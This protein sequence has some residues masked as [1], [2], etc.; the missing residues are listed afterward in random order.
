MVTPPFCHCLRDRRTDPVEVKHLQPNQ[1]LNALEVVRQ[2]HQAHPTLTRAACTHTAQED[3]AHVVFHRTQDMLEPCTNARFL[4]VAQRLCFGLWF[5]AI[6]TFMNP[7]L[8]PTSLE[9]LRLFV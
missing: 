8:V 6:G 5:V 3:T 9:A 2:I 4:C 7:A 1:R